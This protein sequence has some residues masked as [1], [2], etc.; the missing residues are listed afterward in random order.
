MSE[1][2]QHVKHW[3]GSEPL[4]VRVPSAWRLNPWRKTRMKAAGPIVRVA[5]FA[6]TL[7]C[8]RAAARVVARGS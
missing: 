5:R 8:V 3:S 1:S 6:S 4:R 7:G 2:A